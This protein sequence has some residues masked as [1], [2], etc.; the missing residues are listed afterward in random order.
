M[1]MMFLMASTSILE[2]EAVD[3]HYQQQKQDVSSRKQ[4]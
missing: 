2:D 3:K 4:R 1:G